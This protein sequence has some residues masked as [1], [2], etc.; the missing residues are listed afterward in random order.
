MKNRLKWIQIILVLGIALTCC[1]KDDEYKKYMPDGE[2]I[3]LQKPDSVKTFPGKNRIQLEW[4]LVDPKITTCKIFYEQSNFRDS[5]IVP[6]QINGNYANDTFRVI[7]PNLE[8][9]NYRLKIAS[10]DKSGHTSLLVETEET[11]YGKMYESSLRNR[12]LKKTDYK[13]DR[14][15][16]MEWNE[17]ETNETG[18]NLSYTDI[19]NVQKE[20]F[21]DK[22]QT[23]ISLPDFKI[24]ESLFYRTAYKPRPESIDAFYAPKVESNFDIPVTAVA[25]KNTY[26]VKDETAILTAS[27]A[28]SN[29]LNKEV[30]WSWVSVPVGNTTMLELTPGANGTASIK[31]NG[32]GRAKVTAT[33]V[34]GIEASCDV[35][36]KNIEDLIDITASSGLKNTAQ[37]FGCGDHV[38]VGIYYK[39]SDWKY[40]AQASMNGNV[41][42]RSFE[43]GP[44]ICILALSGFPS[45]TMNNGKLYQTVELEAGG[46]RFDVVPLYLGIKNNFYTAAALGDDLPNTEE[47]S[48]NSLNFTR[49]PEQ[50]DYTNEKVSV[51][52]TVTQKSFVSIGFVATLGDGEMAFFSKVE[53]FKF[54]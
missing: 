50:N 4:L 15:L 30:T 3:Y 14:S 36:V 31:A 40:N 24:T 8:E 13:S 46:Y 52:F 51:T 11:V 54:K 49:F 1:T 10:Y 21:V 20:A 7:I 9:T 16:L 2:I 18:I 19:N 43:S 44:S 45:K 28:P 37:P 23:I 47:L 27:V 29:A 42:T 53:L 22:S 48:N 32:L 6:I 41:D 35:Y 17:G 12:V 38:Y 5:L 34:N 33:S 26:M 39:I 25:L